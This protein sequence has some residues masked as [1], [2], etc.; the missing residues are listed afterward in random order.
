FVP[1]ATTSTWTPTQARGVQLV[2]SAPQG[3]VFLDGALSSDWPMYHHDVEHTGL[4]SGPSTISST[5]AG[6]LR[7]KATIPLDGPVISVPVGGA[8]KVYVGTGNSTTATNRSG[9]TLYKVDL[10][11]GTIEKTFPFATSTTPTPGGSRQGYAGI[12]ASPAVVDGK[13]YFSGLDG[14]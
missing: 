4:S 6:R 14:K 10:A 7:L 12:G 11:T 8:V 3:G 1:A 13:V 9:G 2:L 5:T